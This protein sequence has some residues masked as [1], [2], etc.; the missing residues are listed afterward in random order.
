MGSSC[1][2]ANLGNNE[3]FSSNREIE[4]GKKGNAQM[5][6]IAGVASAF[7]R[8]YYR[9]EQITEALRQHWDDGL[10]NPKVLERLLTPSRCRGQVFGF[11]Y[12]G[13]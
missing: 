8:Q 11:T 13:V 1:V 6:R 7:P 5:T 4:P 3:G 12:R 9:Q 2:A 10:E